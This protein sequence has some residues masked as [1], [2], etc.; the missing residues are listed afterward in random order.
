MTP[1]LLTVTL[2]SGLVESQGTEVRVQ[3]RNWLG[4]SKCF[5]TWEG[6]TETEFEVSY[7]T[8]NRAINLLAS[9]GHTG[10]RIVWDV[11]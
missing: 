1:T 3:K 5:T 8:L 9:L 10:Y 6:F 11:Q 2:I 4:R 7:V